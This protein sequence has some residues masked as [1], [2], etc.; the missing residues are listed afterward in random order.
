VDEIIVALPKPGHPEIVELA[1]RCRTHGIAVSVIPHPYELYLSRTQLIDLDG[2]PLLQ[3]R[4]ANVAT[5][6]PGWQRFMDSA[7]GSFLFVLALPAM[8]MGATLLKIK[9]GRALCRELRCGKGGDPF[10]MYRLNSERYASDLPP[11][12]LILQ[13]FS[14]TELPQLWNVLR[15]EMSLVGPRPESPE[16]VKHYSD[17]HKQRL[18]VK[19]GIT[20][21]A[22]VHGLRDQHSSEDKTRFDLQYILNR[23]VFIYISLLLQTFWTIAV[24]LV[25]LP[26]LRPETP[27]VSQLHRELSLKETFTS[28]HS[29]QSSAD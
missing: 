26:H 20:G 11:Y 15:G 8:F 7:L 25:R 10:W 9:K 22:Q 13:H 18:N 27:V 29:T 24:R 2:L 23:S 14:V 28:A 6:T 12:E 4:D 3:L 1:A 19:P 21:L 16:K 17:W 5:G